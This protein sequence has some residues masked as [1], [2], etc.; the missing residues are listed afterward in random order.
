MLEALEILTTMTFWAAAL[1]IATPYILGTLGELVCERAGVLNLGIEGILTAGAMSGWI[2]VYFGA[3]LWSGVLVAALVGAGLGLLH[4]LLTVPLGLS[5]H[6]TGLGITLL[7]T[8]ASYFIYRIVL[9]NVSTPPR[10]EP[11][12]PLD[13]PGLSDLPL[14]GPALF[15]QTPLTYLAVL[16]VVIVA[17]VLAKTPL[18]LAIRTVGENPSAAEA[19]GLNVY[20]L[21]IG[22]VMAGSA[23][24]A[25]GGAFLTLSAFNAFFFEMVA[26]R[27]WICI[28]L[29]VFA[30]WNPWKALFGALL[31][32][33][34]DAFQVRLQQIAGAVVPYQVFLMLPYALSIAA[35]VAMSRR[36]SYP[37]AL[38]VPYV[39]GQR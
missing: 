30:S 11:F 35:L 31:F 34:F 29:V 6:V 28:A 3:D 2:A 5:Q 14:V 1:R 22:A 25:V 39:K 9:P 7:A 24:M 15:Q 19:Q 36:A 32:G 23:L 26:G 38:M 21:R 12:A 37:N 33:A 16:L 8:S 13:L 10:I 27:G 18:G 4:A 20:A 17:Y